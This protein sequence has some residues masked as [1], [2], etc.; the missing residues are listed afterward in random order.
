MRPGLVLEYKYASLTL[1]LFFAPPLRLFDLS[2]DPL[3]HL[4]MFIIPSLDLAIA[5]SK[6]LKGTVLMVPVPARMSSEPLPP[7]EWRNPQAIKANYESIL[8]RSPH[9]GELLLL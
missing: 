5:H 3:A 6:V 4:G 7:T 1:F 8:V 2:D 9:S